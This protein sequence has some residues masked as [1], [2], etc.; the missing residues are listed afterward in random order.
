MGLQDIRD[1]LARTLTACG[2]YV[3]AEISACDF[4]ILESTSA[5]AIVFTP[6]ADTVFEAMTFGAA[7][8]DAKS[9]SIDGAV[10]VK[11]TGD[12]LLFFGRVWQAHDDFFNTV[13]KDRSLNSTAKFGRV[14]S[15]SY[16]PDVGRE[17]G[18]AFWG[19]IKFRVVAEE[20][21]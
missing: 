15:M 5:C 16:N 13:K 1:G 12:P 20:Y 9:W 14:V 18:G 19:E 7:G 6:G 21:S 4:G 17:A 10:Y 11:D 2:P 3:D 8:V